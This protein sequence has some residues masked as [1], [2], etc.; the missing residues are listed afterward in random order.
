M[1]R[2]SEGVQGWVGA[3]SGMVYISA[4]ILF[5]TAVRTTLWLQAVAGSK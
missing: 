2:L 5:C 3:H 1:C 4:V